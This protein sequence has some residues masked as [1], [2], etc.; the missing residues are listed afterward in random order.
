[1]AGL[2]GYRCCTPDYRPLVE[3]SVV[4]VDGEVHQV[5]AS[6]DNGVTL[7]IPKYVVGEGLLYS[8]PLASRLKRLVWHYRPGEVASLANT[9]DPCFDAKTYTLSWS[10]APLVCDPRCRREELESPRDELE[11][12][13]LELIT[14]LRGLGVEAYPTGS[15]LGYYHDPRISDIDL[16]VYVDSRGGCKDIIEAV[17]ALLEP[18]PPGRVE[19]WARARGVEP[20]LYRRWVRG[21]YHGREVSI[22]FALGAP[23]RYCEIMIDYGGLRRIVE[24]RLSLEPGGCRALT[25]PHFTLSKEGLLIVSFDGVYAPMLFEGGCVEATGLKARVSLGGVWYDAIILGVS[26]AETRIV[27][28]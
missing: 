1:M 2:S 21:V 16:V 11:E 22:V 7:L 4:Y 24:R 8:K 14:G 28:C 18:L 23:R 6:Y 27:R 19:A 15:I 20:G 3:R 17:A 25:W 12:E 10:H 13:A 26:E 5:L 9:H